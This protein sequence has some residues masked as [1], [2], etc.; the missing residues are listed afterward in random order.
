MKLIAVLLGVLSRVNDVLLAVGRRIAMAAMVLMVAVILLQIFYR[1]VLDNALPWP[2]EA[3]RGLMIWMTAMVAP[4]AYRYAG[5]VSID[6]LPEMLPARLKAVLG[7]AIMLLCTT[8]LLVMLH[9][10]WAQ[11]TAPLLFDSSGLNRLLQN[12]GINDLLGTNMQFR[13]AYIYLSMSVLVSVMLLVSIELILRELGRLIW[14]AG[15]FPPLTVPDFSKE[16]S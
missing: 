1:Y 12:S 7:L 4:T 2:E 15:E 6:M 8:V 16:T 9:H 5:F 14:S 10:A 13:T 3:A 11:F